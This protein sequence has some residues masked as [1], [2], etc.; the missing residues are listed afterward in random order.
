MSHKGSVNGPSVTFENG[1]MN[2][3]D[4]L[5]VIPRLVERS[6]SEFVNK[7]ITDGCEHAIEVL[8]GEPVY[9]SSTKGLVKS[10]NK[11]G[12]ERFWQPEAHLNQD[13]ATSSSAPGFVSVPERI[14]INSPRI[15]NALAAIDPSIDATEPIVMLRPF[16]FLLYHE[17]QIR[18]GGVRLQDTDES[19]ENAKHMQCLGEF[20]DKYIK[21]TNDRCD[22]GSYSKVRF[23]DLWY[24]FIT[25]ENIYMPLRSLQKEAVTVDAM[26]AAPET[27]QTRYNMIWRL[28]ATGGGRSNIS[29][30]KD[31]HKSLRPNPFSVNCYYIDFDGKYFCPIIHTFSIMPFKGEKEITSL[32]F[33]PVRYMQASVSEPMHKGK[34]TFES[35]ASSF[36][37][38]YYEGP[39]L[40]VHPCGCPLQKDPLH[41]ENVE[42]EVIVDFRMALLTNPSWRPKAPLWKHP[43]V[44]RGE[45]VEKTPVRVWKD[46]SRT[47]LV[48]SDHDHVYDDNQIERELSAAVRNRER[49]FA[50][51]P[52]GWLSNESMLPENDVGLLPGRVYGFVLR[53]RTYGEHL[54]R[55][56]R[57]LNDVC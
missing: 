6:W 34:M 53:T 44:E 45:L 25:G 56:R 43:P 46:S 24:L 32:E 54:K 49:I 38:F 8:V 9:R 42:S 16:K 17:G 12:K 50:P 1:G 4:D 57:K 35:I 3:T 41:Q 31:R 26:K 22:T 33:Y 51:V 15:L 47:K 2:E 55:I 52:S 14:R 37:H 19:Q 40:V 23:C 20:I 18:A 28:I 27:F 36:T 29:D 7:C 10:Y 13:P 11:R 5:P 30:A 48:R 39:T 21:P